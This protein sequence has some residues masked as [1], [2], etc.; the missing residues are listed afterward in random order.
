MHKELRYL[1]IACGGGIAGFIAWQGTQAIS[2][3][4]DEQMPKL[5]IQGVVSL[6]LG[7]VSIIGLLVSAFAPLLLRES[8]LLQRVTICAALSLP[9]IDLIAFV[10]YGGELH[11]TTGQVFFSGLL[12]CVVALGISSAWL[13]YFAY[14]SDSEPM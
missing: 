13:R 3:S 10:P 1:L 9:V 5:F 4:A 8:W 7:T 12:A 6:L 11:A 2:V 14:K